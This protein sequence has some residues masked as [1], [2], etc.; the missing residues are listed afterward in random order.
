LILDNVLVEI[1]K[2]LTFNCV[3]CDFGYAS[4][5]DGTRTFVAGVSKP[6]SIGISTRY[7]SPELF[8]KALK[9]AVRFHLEIDKKIDVYAFAITVY[10]IGSLE[11]AWK[12]V[13]A[14]DIQKMVLDGVRPVFNA[15]FKE[16]HENVKNLESLIEECWEDNPEMRPSFNEI[17]R[18]IKKMFGNSSKVPNEATMTVLNY[19]LEMKV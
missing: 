18:R 13:P 11:D 15:K 9:T 8:Q 10:E 5:V 14:A 17:E 16:L 19:S 4:F 12:D 3:V 1:D 2:N 6:K 7:A